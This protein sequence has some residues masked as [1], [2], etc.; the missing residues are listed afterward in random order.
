MFR[1]FAVIL[2]SLHIFAGDCPNLDPQE[3][4]LLTKTARLWTPEQD[5]LL[6][7][8]CTKRRNASKFIW[9]KIGAQVP[10][11][12]SKQCRER[13][14]NHLDPTINKSPFSEEEITLLN[15]AVKKYGTQW[16][17]IAQTY[18]IADDG[19]R[20]TDLQLRNRWNS[21][22]N[23]SLRKTNEWKDSRK[24]RKIIESDNVAV[25]ETELIIETPPETSLTIELIDHQ[26]PDN[27]PLDIFLSS[28]S[29]ILSENTQ[30]FS[31]TTSQEQSHK[32]AK[33]SMWTSDEDALLISSCYTMQNSWKKIAS[34]IPG[35]TPASCQSRYK[36][37]MKNKRLLSN[38]EF[39]FEQFISTPDKNQS[40]IRSISPLSDISLSEETF[41]KLIEDFF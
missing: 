38:P 34:N 29:A 10:M 41:A 9:S 12:N 4:N 16:T 22:I 14:Q 7:E 25:E 31:L 18:F 6:V 11:K 33:Y 21:Q 8:N 19:T 17:K 27:K 39:E 5:A 36:L 1:A 3:K 24:K 37:L 28:S 32:K 15:K 13:Y 30:Q 20:R 23:K 40:D 26:L 2:F 35:R